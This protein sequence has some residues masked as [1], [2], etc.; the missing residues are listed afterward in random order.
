MRL[1]YSKLDIA[2]FKLDIAHFKLDIAHFKL[3]IAHF[4]LDIAHFKLDKACLVSTGLL[5][6]MFL[7]SL[8]MWNNFPVFPLFYLKIGCLEF[9]FG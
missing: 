5:T 6:V 8:R 1:R 3:D 7:S 9:I 4:K 2:H